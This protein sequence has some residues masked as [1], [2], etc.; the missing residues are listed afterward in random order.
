MVLHLACQDFFLSLIAVLEEFLYDIVA[1]NIRHQL[2][3]IRADFTKDLVF[4]VAVGRLELLLNKSRTML[5]AAKLYNVIVDILQ[6]SAI[7]P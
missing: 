6:S 1:K 5:V 7:V 3:R 4:L 2:Q